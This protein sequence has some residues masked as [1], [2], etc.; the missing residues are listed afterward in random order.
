MAKEWKFTPKRKHSILRASKIH[1]E[2]VAL[3]KEAYYK[4]HEK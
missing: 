3:G 1:K 4:R 2:M